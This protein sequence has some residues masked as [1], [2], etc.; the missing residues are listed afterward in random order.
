VY[1]DNDWITNERSQV[2]EIMKKNYA[3]VHTLL[4]K[5][6]SSKSYIYI[7]HQNVMGVG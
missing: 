1:A 2:V 6:S 4:Q 7:N 3:H 5:R